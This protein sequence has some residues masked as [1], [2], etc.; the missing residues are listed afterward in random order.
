MKINEKY[1]LRILVAEDNAINQK[2]IF[3]MFENLGYAIQLAANGYE[4]LELLSRMN[5][6]IVFMDIQMPEMDGIEA[7]RKII[8]NLG[9]QKPLIVAMT[10]NAL[11]TDKDAYLAAGMDD[12][13]NK[14][15]T[16][17]QVRTGIEKWTT[18]RDAT[19]KKLLL[20]K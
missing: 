11:S 8:E 13:I 16:I 19:Q 5:I 2:L 18:M 20:K 3:R 14:P 9:D 6:D 15:I 17:D 10:A 7:T 4:V 1:P 12:Y